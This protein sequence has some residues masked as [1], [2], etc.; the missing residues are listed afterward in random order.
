MGLTSLGKLAI[1]AG[2][3]EGDLA[4]FGSLLG[5]SS[6]ER[7]HVAH[8][9]L[10]CQMPIDDYA[11]LVGTWKNGEGGAQPLYL[12]LAAKTVHAAAQAI[13]RPAVAA[14]AT[15]V[16]AGPS[17]SEVN[18]ALVALA[19]SMATV[20]KPE[21]RRVKTSNVAD[22]ADES[23]IPVASADQL[24]EWYADYCRLKHG[25]P[26]PDKEPTGEQVSALHTRIVEL[27]ME[28]YADFSVLTPHGRR[29]AKVLRHRSWL[30][31]EDGSYKPVEVP[32][33]SSLG[34]WDACWKVYERVLLMLRFKDADTGVK[35]LVIKPIALDAY[36]KAFSQLAKEHP[37]TWHLCCSAE[38]KCRAEHMPRILRRLEEE[39]GCQPSWSDVFEAAAA[40]NAFWDREVRRPSLQF[41]ARGSLPRPEATNQAERAVMEKT[42]TNAGSG[43]SGERPPSRRQAKTEKRKMAISAGK[44]AAGPPPK[45]TKGSGKGAHP[46]KDRD[47]LF[48]STET[49]DEICFR[50]AK[51][52]GDGGCSTPCGQSRKHVCQH[53]LG[54]HKNASCTKR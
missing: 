30:P 46:R 14:P 34:T 18:A 26:L 29:L 6:A 4:S 24:K 32:G 1:W 54:S 13:C 52:S 19:K 39:W 3:E 50:F 16:A 36:Y 27:G 38:D 8:V 25:H 40:D 33:P 41:L 12:S 17:T 47:G 45:K 5:F 10:L 20:P 35:Y 31:Q 11:T 2:M 28:P 53:C 51:A 7:V 49:G 15:P 21:G 42:A 43:R 22:P 23:E 9:R 44:P 48:L 37:E